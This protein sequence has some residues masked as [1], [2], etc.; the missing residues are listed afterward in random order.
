MPDGRIRNT[1]TGVVHLMPRGAARGF[2][3]TECGVYRPR[4]TTGWSNPCSDDVVVTCLRCA[5]VMLW[6]VMP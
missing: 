3:L 4:D 1:R 2:L 5:R 6:Q